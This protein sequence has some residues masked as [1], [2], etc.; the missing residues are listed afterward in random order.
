VSRRARRAALIL[1]A[2]SIAGLPAALRAETESRAREPAA[3][4]PLHECPAPRP[5][6]DGAIGG[7]RRPLARVDR[8]LASR[9]AQGDPEAA[10]AVALRYFDGDC[11]RKSF[12]EAHRWFEIAAASG[13]ACALA[14]A[15]HLKAE[16]LG[17]ERDPA[18]AREGLQAAQLAGCRR[19][20]YLQALL[21]ET[22]PRPERQQLARELLE[23]GTAL[24]D[25][26]ALN[27]L[28]AERE[29]G[30][31]RQAA[32][33]L[34][35]RA[36][37]A[38]NRAAPVNLK[39]LDR[40]FSQRERKES[41]DSLRRRAQA[42]EPAAL[43]ALAQRYHRGDGVAADYVEA[44]KLYRGAAQANHPPA[45]EMLALILSRPAARGGIDVAWMQSLAAAP[46][47]T[48]EQ[49]KRRGVLQPVIDDD[50]FY[51]MAPRVDAPAAVPSR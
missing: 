46:L 50:P 19:A 10:F 42:K 34:Y 44:L 16:G 41:I 31:E 33:A 22:S 20:F 2:A 36:A 12:A 38:G 26:H 9:A 6:R 23:R 48:D 21:E 17:V 47:A 32:E 8:E 24:G 13:H 7:A 15:S 51:G 3:E 28:G 29:R 40:Y 11:V 27:L 18:T 43:F 39:R 25:G 4:E 14:A 30:G 37:A 5:D 49:G 35:R 1:I 45:V